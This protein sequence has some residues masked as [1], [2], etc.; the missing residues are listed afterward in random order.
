MDNYPLSSNQWPIWFEQILHPDE[1]LFN[2]GGYMRIN[3]PLEPV[4][5]EAALKQVIAEN[6]AL[7]IIIRQVNNQPVQSFVTEIPFQLE[8]H[9]F[10]SPDHDHQVVLKWIQQ[11]LVKPFSLYDQ[12]L[13]QFALYK[14]SDTSY[15]WFKKYHHLIIDGWGASLIAQRVAAAYNTLITGQ[16]R[17]QQPLYSYR[18]WLSD[19]QAYLSSE[20][21]EQHQSYWQNQFREPPA[22]LFPRRHATTRQARRA[23]LLVKRA[24]YNQL[25]AFAQKN[26]VSIQHIVLGILYCYFIRIAQRD[27]LLIGLVTLNRSHAV[28]K[29]TVGMFAKFTPAW[30]QFGTGLSFVEL[31]QAIRQAL[32]KNYRYQRLPMVDINRPV[33]LNSHRQLFDITLSYAKHDYDIDFNGSPTRTV[34]LNNGFEANA[35]LAIWVEEFHQGE[36]VNIYF[37]YNLEAFEE[38][39]IERFKTGFEFLL[40]EVLRQSLVP[41]RELQLMPEAERQQVLVEFNDTAVDY[42]RD[43]TI[44]DGFEEQVEQTPYQIAIVFEEQQLTYQALN[45][46]ANQLAHHLLG[47]GVK[48]NMLVALCLERSLEMVIGILGILKAGGAYLPLDPTYP[49]AH[50]AF[51]LENA[52]VPVLLTQSGLVDKLRA[53]KVPLICLDT[54][55]EKFSPLNRD[56]PNRNSQAI[57]LIY[58][59]YT[60]GSS[61]RP[62]GAGIYQRSFLNLLNWFIKTFKLTAR[63][64][65]LLITSFSFDLTQKNIFAPLLVGGTLH[66][67]PSIPYDPKLI[68]QAIADKQITWINTTPGAFYPLIDSVHPDNYRLLSSLR[69]LLLGG[70]PISMPRLLP[71]LNSTACQAKLVN[72]YGPTEC[73]DIC[74]AYLVEEPEQWLEKSVPIGKP[75]PN[76][77][78]L[79]LDHNQKLLPLG[80][81]GE[82]YIA[83]EGVGIGY[84]NNAELTQERFILWNEDSKV[85][86]YKTGDLVRW[87]PDGNLESLG[88]LDNQV[89][90]RGFRIEPGE[91]EVVLNQHPKVLQSVVI[92]WE[93]H[94]GDER[95]AAYYVPNLAQV[96]TPSKLHHFL[97]E[98]LPHYMV[99]SFLVRLENLPLTPNGKIDRYHLPTPDPFQRDIEEK[100]VAPQTQTETRLVDIWAQVLEHENIGIHDNFFE[101]GGHSLLA[102]NLMTRI[103]HAFGIHL[104]LATLF[105][106]PTIK[107]LARFLDQTTDSQVWS[108]LVA[109][110]P[111]GSKSPFFCM[112]GSGGNIVPFHQ[113]ARL[114]GTERPFY[115]MQARG[116]DGQSAPFTRVEEV[117][118]Y[119]LEAIR[120]VQPQ[121]PYFL[122]GYSFGALVAFEMAQQLHRQGQRVAF[123]AILDLPALRPDREPIEL[124]W[125]E[126][127]WMAVIAQII[128]SLSGKTLGLCYE[129]FL[130]LDADAQLKLLKEHLE[131]ANLLPPEAS[132]NTVRALVRVSKADGLAFFRYLPGAGYPHRITLFRTREAYHDELGA[133]GDILSAPDWGWGY[134]STE[135]V[136]VH[137]VP[138]NHAT[139][140][141]EPQ[142]LVL[143][144]KLTGA[145]P[146]S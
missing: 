12:P 19:D 55:V 118:V 119:Y 63:D 140:L 7:R 88:R 64:R 16:P 128:E 133:F 37:N 13:F 27:D 33:R 127:K 38:A 106:Q 107:H 113:L 73:T 71:W 22:P 137:V 74:A 132:I 47:L 32:Q 4:I 116:L 70:E 139:M 36:D 114:M 126:A 56:N 145:M 108:P 52:E 104:P 6:D 87:L 99:P 15:Y 95:L 61:G 67:W 20:K 25:M 142:V 81:A 110:Q 2:I 134:L 125:D 45:Q 90:I 5:L 14:V 124:D 82:L 8:V 72:T 59:I 46:K 35:L 50:L 41:I 76:V 91:I 86:C 18:E 23:I 43:K 143:A 84:L 122:G 26:H 54:E 85:R 58:A 3:G 115:A 131:S 102:V 129:D 51:M 21:F 10:S 120:A 130:A 53:L 9:D 75:I 146:L 44:A 42:P 69:W 123:L 80:I 101:L 135:P 77:K 29:Q 93:I 68:I 62:K 105:K 94:P 60:S 78:L 57:Q 100:L 65:V 17:S 136:D 40:G 109:L 24:G 97:R 11:E 48:P 66:L 30:F 98:Q 31:I 111:Q 141:I 92:V 39:E 103:E 96:P 144:E 49:A 112:P 28:F 34:S 117:A 89:K 1:P 83:G 121:G 79:V 138:G